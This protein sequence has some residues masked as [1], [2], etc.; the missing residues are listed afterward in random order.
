MAGRRIPPAI[1][2]TYDV[3]L[4]LECQEQ[5]RLLD[6]GH[7]RAAPGRAI[8]PQ[9]K[10]VRP[11]HTSLDTDL[12][13]L[14]QGSPIAAEG[15]TLLRGVSYSG[16]AFERS[17]GDVVLDD[18]KLEAGA[19]RAPMAQ[20]KFVE[21]DDQWSDPAK[22]LGRVTLVC[23]IAAALGLLGLLMFMGKAIDTIE[24]P[25]HA[26]AVSKLIANHPADSR[27]ATSF[28]FS[29]SYYLKDCPCQSQKDA[30]L[31]IPAG[32]SSIELSASD[33][34]NQQT[35]FQG[36]FL[37]KTAYSETD[38]GGKQI[39]EKSLTYL[40]DDDFGFTFH[41]NAISLAA[42]LAEKDSRAFF[43]VD[44][45]WDRGTWS[46]HFL[47]M[48]DPG[49]APPPPSEMAGCPRSTRHWI[50]TS[51]ILSAHFSKEF[52]ESFGDNEDLDQV[53]PEPVP[54]LIPSSRKSIYQMA[55]STFFR[56]FILSEAN[57]QLIRKTKQEIIKSA[58]WGPSSDLRLPPFISVHIRKGDRHPHDP[59][60]TYDYVP[61]NYYIDSINSTWTRLRDEDPALPESPNVYLASDTPLALEQM[62]ALTPASWKFFHLSEAGSTEI[63]LIAHPHEYSQL[64][65]HAHI[66]SERVGYTRGQVIDMAFLGG[67]WPKPDGSVT[68]SSTDSEKPLATICTV[69]SNMCQFGALQ[70]GWE[71]AFE[72][73]KWINLDLPL[74]A[75][76]MG[77]EVPAANT[78]DSNPN[79]HG[80][81]SAHHS[82]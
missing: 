21:E 54:G 16:D 23:L 44:L 78:G 37:N 10:L 20:G 38:Q 73:S 3:S 45:E 64:H 70:L 4:D 5:R 9:P 67:G 6:G 33:L 50:V 30:Q 76:W 39:C 53:I 52:M 14:F 82:H 7:I 47:K 26:N 15:A 12:S 24:G 18:L 19:A 51:S 56:L 40:L 27:L 28:P 80:H 57:D 79:G 29:P 55:R 59:A 11:S 65:F 13:P 61:I 41:L 48:P 69:S 62:R 42:A 58:V 63:S 22:G 75:G 8:S 46:D 35:Y 66:V 71:E 60:H 31:S 36:R 74:S 2:T 72:K 68:L 49:C 17:Y 43:I 81:G 34:F 77:V 32:S 25:Q 1:N